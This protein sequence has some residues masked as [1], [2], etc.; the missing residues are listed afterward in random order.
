[1][2]ASLNLT[3][4]QI[5]MALGMSGSGVRKIQSRWLRQGEAV[6]KEPGKGGPHHRRLTKK[7]ERAFLDRLLKMTLPAN[8][9]MNVRF[10]QQEFE[11]MVGHPVAYTVVYRMV[12]RHGWRPTRDIHMAT[13]PRWEAAKLPLTDEWS[14]NGA[15]DEARADADTGM[16]DAELE[17]AIKDYDA[18]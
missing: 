4:D 9:V 17:A 8:A 7:V 2:R 12:K 6:F 10:V 11:K 3:S 5:A 14:P 18:P 16:S 1:M 13:P 15:I